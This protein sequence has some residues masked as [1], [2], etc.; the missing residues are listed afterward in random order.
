MAD[1]TFFDV[2]WSILCEIK[3]D[4][5]SIHALKSVN[6]IQFTSEACSRSSLRPL[7]RQNRSRAIRWAENLACEISLNTSS[8]LCKS[9][10]TGKNHSRMNRVNDEE[11]DRAC[12]PHKICA[13]R[14]TWDCRCEHLHGIYATFSNGRLDLG[15][16]RAPKPAP[17]CRKIVWTAIF[18][19]IAEH[20]IDGRGRH[21]WYATCIRRRIRRDTTRVKC[22]SPIPVLVRCHF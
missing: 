18:H 6:C 20:P 7:S 11:I 15:A 9:R 2:R 16:K 1:F 5:E 19:K 3:I 12:V 17:G 13:T 10:K 22:H 21:L 14:N 8:H 4:R